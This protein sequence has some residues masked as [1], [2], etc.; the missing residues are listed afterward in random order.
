[1]DFFD[2]L[3]VG[4][5]SH[6]DYPVSVQKNFLEKLGEAT[7]DFDCSFRQYKGQMFFMSKSKK[8]LL[9]ILSLN[10]AAL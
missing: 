2:K 10:S 1:M 5:K 8:S 3:F 6:Y 4:E 9:S 7:D